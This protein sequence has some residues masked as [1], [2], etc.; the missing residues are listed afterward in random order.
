MPIGELRPPSSHLAPLML[1]PSMT[2]NENPVSDRLRSF[3]KEYITSLEQLEILLLLSNEPGRTWNIE[4]V[5]K[6]T[7]SNHASVAERLRSLAGVG[8]LAVED[9]AGTV[10][11]FRPKSPELTDL[12]KEL[13]RTYPMARARIIEIIF[14]G[15]ISQAQHFADSFKFKRNN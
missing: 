10:F 6:V 9:D 1:Q 14:S 12:V 11:R 2:P 7:Q 15:K 4:Q 8:F 13:G 3:L 5:F